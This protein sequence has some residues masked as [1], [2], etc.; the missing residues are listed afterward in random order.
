MFHLDVKNDFLYGDLIENVYMEQP[1]WFVSQGK[2]LQ[3]KEG[4]L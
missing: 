3:I 2:S 4:N 1:L